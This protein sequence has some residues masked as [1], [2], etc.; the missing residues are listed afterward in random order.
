MLP[1]RWR[2][3][4]A[5]E[6]NSMDTDKD[7]PFPVKSTAGPGTVPDMEEIKFQRISRKSPAT[8]GPK[9]AKHEVIR[10]WDEY[11]RF[12]DDKDNQNR[13]E[14]NFT[15]EQVI[16]VSMGEQTSEGYSIEIVKIR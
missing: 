4:G 16:A 13:P 8:S 15:T 11:D 1:N 6:I 2:V 5:K 10:S 9:Q 12:F 14:V 3:A 7:G